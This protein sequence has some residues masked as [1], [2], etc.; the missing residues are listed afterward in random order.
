MESLY[1]LD[2]NYYYKIYTNLHNM[3]KDR[4]F[5]PK[6]Q[7]MDLTEYKTKLIGHL[8]ESS[9]KDNKLAPF[10]F[11]D[12]LSIIF[13]KNDEKV[14]VY[15]YILDTKIKKTDMEHVNALMIKKECSSVI[16]II[17]EKVTSRVSS[18][19]DLIDKSQ[20]FYEKELCYNPINHVLAPKYKILSKEEIDELLESYHI[21]LKNLP[22]IFKNQPVPKYYNLQEGSVIEIHRSDNSLY[23]RTVR[24]E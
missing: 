5:T 13:T 10:F 11:I 20:V 2:F 8:A 14:L 17:K 6:K 16:L 19:L 12:S 9:E 21:T 7:K 23:Y 18:I 24:N 4:G 15:F 22:G 3:M 1:D